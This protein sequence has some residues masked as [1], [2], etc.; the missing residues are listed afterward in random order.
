MELR[1]FEPHDS[2][3]IDELC[4]VTHA[5]VAD[6]KDGILRAFSIHAIW[7]FAVMAFVL[8]VQ[9]DCVQEFFVRLDSFH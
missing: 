8:L 2:R 1:I 7:L 9:S 6:A 3:E 4:A 5:K